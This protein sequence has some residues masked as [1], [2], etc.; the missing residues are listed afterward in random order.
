MIDTVKLM[1]IPYVHK[2]RDEKGVDCLGLVH[3]VFSEFGIQIPDEDYGTR[4]YSKEVSERFLPNMIEFKEVKD[5]KMYDLVLFKSRK[6]SLTQ[7]IGICLNNFSFIHASKAGV[8]IGRL[9]V[10]PW[11]KLKLGYY[12]H[13]KF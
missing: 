1:R 12:R 4:W 8:T 13:A 11:R 6:K 10:D 5:P 3:L 9:G 2:G 7:H